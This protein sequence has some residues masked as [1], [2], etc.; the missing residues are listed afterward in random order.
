MPVSFASSALSCHEKQNQTVIP[1][2]LMFFG[3]LQSPETYETLIRSQPLLRA[4]TWIKQM[5]EDYPPGIHEIQGEDLF[6][7]IHG[8]D[9]CPV[10][11]CRFESHR[12][13]VDIQYCIEGGERI[14]LQWA[15]RLDPDGDFDQPKDLQFYHPQAGGTSLQMT[16]GDFA[17]F[18]PQDAHRPRVQDGTNLS[19]RKLV[20]KINLALLGQ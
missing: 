9:T 6:V 17:I 12:K 8:Y 7:N 20:V 19:V 2:C 13:Y 11:Q 3:N 14:D 5:P 10:E 1:S 16:P 15:S 18:F 4:L